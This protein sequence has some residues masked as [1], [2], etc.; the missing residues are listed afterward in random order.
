MS[1]YR[2]GFRPVTAA[3][4]SEDVADQ[5]FV[6]SNLPTLDES[7]LGLVEY[8]QVTRA[9]SELVEPSS[10][11][12]KRGK[13]SG[14]YTHYT[15]CW[16]NLKESTI[17]SF[18]TAY[19]KKLDEEMKKAIPQPVIQIPTKPKGRPPILDLDEKL[20]KFLKAVRAKGGV[21]NAHIV[22]AAVTAL[23][24]KSSSSQHL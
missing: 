9:V 15:R 24:E 14:S 22:R 20:I 6:S 12:K 1:L 8:N 16:P 2:F 4:D 11:K 18:K 21:V 5:P 17:R 13:S 7:G 3:Q 23:I 10:S 19:K